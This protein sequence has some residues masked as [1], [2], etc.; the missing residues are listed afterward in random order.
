MYG[1]AARLKKTGVYPD[2]WHKD[3]YRIELRADMPFDIYTVDSALE[4]LGYHITD[5]DQFGWSYGKA[6]YPYSSAELDESDDPPELPQLIL[7]ESS[8]EESQTEW[9]REQ[10]YSVYENIY[11][12]CRKEWYLNDYNQ[13]DEPEDFKFAQH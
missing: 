13:W 5:A 3:L 11:E 1:T 4:E 7:E 2:R 12:I 6:N 8:L 9:M 10:L